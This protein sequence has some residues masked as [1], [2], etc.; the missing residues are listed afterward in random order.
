MERIIRYRNTQTVTLDDFIELV[1]NKPNCSYCQYYQECSE[2]VGCDMCEIM[3][4]ACSSFDNS[5]IEL[6]KLYFQ[7]YVNKI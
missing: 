2:N 7:K 1:L 5:I 6:K 4:E 3:D